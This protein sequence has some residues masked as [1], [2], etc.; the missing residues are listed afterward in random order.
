MAAACSMCSKV[1]NM[2]TRAN[3][4]GHHGDGKNLPETNIFYL[5]KFKIKNVEFWLV[6]FFKWK[7]NG[8][9]ILMFS[10]L[11]QGEFN[12]KNNSLKFK[13][14]KIGLRGW[15]IHVLYFSLIL[16]RNF[17]FPQRSFLL[18]HIH[19]SEKFYYSNCD[20]PGNNILKVL[21]CSFSTM[22]STSPNSFSLAHHSL[23]HQIEI[24]GQSHC[25]NL[26]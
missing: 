13:W 9:P 7:I 19:M 16:T 10:H 23:L 12:W 20:F 8:V 24:V 21:L 17:C 11:E 5:K 3:K 15:K 26:L 2:Q 18:W 1:H 22:G 4:P 25:I 6:Q 14:I